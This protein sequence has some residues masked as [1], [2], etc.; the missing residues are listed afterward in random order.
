MAIQTEKV[1]SIVI[2]TY[3][4]EDY[5][6]RC[7]SSL[8]IDKHL[9]DLEVW[10]VN[11]GST[12]RSKAIAEAY[13]K[14][15]AGIF[16]LIDKPNG[17]YGSCINAALPVTR[18]RYVK[19][20]DAD[21]RFE[22]ANLARLVET[23]RTIDVDLVMTDLIK[24]YTDGHHKEEHL[25]LPA[26]RILPFDEIC[27][28]PSVRNL[29]MH[30]VTYRTRNLQEMGYRQAEG[31]SYTDQQWIF[32]P[33][34]TVRTAYYLNMPVYRYLLGREGQTVGKSHTNRNFHHNVV[35]TNN[36]LL[37]WKTLPPCS[38]AVKGL[39][40]YKL[41]RRLRL[42]YRTYLLR[43]HDF[44]NPYLIDLDEKLQALHPQMYEACGRLLMSKPLFCVRF[45]RLWRQ[46][47]RSRRL[48]WLVTLYGLLH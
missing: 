5:L 39:L 44:D 15:Y 8:L 20:L 10:V 22:T 25:S 21:D 2:P 41:L 13:T 45:I 37:Q 9:E 19:I 11:D 36:M 34:S 7:L 27:H 1:L 40:N 38:E 31:I 47:H 3:N 30:N 28:E 24:D 43:Q 23:L 6:D 48:H 17:N 29:W 32:A 26:G 16:F 33:L 46:N 12:D 42:I 35:C 18:G 14:R 4:M